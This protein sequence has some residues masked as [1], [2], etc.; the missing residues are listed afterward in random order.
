[1]IA[2]FGTN[3]QTSTFDPNL[4]FDMQTSQNGVWQGASGITGQYQQQHYQQQPIQQQPYQQQT[5]DGG[6][7]FSVAPTPYNY[8]YSNS[9]GGMGS[10]ADSTQMGGY[11][12]T[13]VPMS[14]SLQSDYANTNMSNGTMSKGMGNGFPIGGVLISSKFKPWHG[15]LGTTFGGNYLACAAGIAVLVSVEGV[16]GSLPNISVSIT[17]INPSS[18]IRIFS[19][20]FHEPQHSDHTY[21]NLLAFLDH[22][23]FLIGINLVDLRS[24]G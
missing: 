11:P 10:F 19:P 17:N 12:T 21:S 20:E 3:L 6:I 13:L 7:G 16:R 18:F 14:A 23:I 5:N 15:M 22:A 1:M 4:G 2:G 9:G 24:Q 8:S